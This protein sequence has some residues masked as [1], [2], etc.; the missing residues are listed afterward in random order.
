MNIDKDG[1]IGMYRAMLGEIDV[2]PDKFAGLKSGDTIWYGRYRR[3]HGENKVSEL[4][5]G[6]MTVA[7]LESY[8]GRKKTIFPPEFYTILGDVDDVRWTRISDGRVDLDCAF[9]PPDLP[10]AD[11]H[12]GSESI[13]PGE[14]GMRTI[15]RDRPGEYVVLSLYRENVARCLVKKMD[16]VVET[17][18]T[19][20]ERTAEKYKRS[21]SEYDEMTKIVESWNG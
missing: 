16:S 12:D 6:R 15:V 10:S 19:A 13:I 3:N 2:A 14:M 18:K 5:I 4:V 8:G 17:L 21:L 7:A 20:A 1:F 9:E 11:S